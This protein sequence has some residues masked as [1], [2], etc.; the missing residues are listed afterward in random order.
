M[1]REGFNGRCDLAKSCRVTFIRISRVWVVISSSSYHSY[2]KSIMPGIYFAGTHINC[3]F[4]LVV[5]NV[6]RGKSIIAVVLGVVLILGPF[7]LRRILMW[8]S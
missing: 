8:G 1:V 4:R 7:A 2:T 5:T 6:S 3:A